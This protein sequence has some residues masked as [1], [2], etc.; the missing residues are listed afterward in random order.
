ML[1]IEQGL[2]KLQ[3]FDINDLRLLFHCNILVPKKYPRKTQFKT[4]C[5]VMLKIIYEQYIS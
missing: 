2:Q 4:Q 3:K 1:S 5:H